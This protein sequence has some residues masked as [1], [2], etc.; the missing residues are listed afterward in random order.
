MI[1]AVL[2]NGLIFP[3]D[4][5][6]SHWKDGQ[7]LRVK[8]LRARTEESPEEIDRQFQALEAAAQ[9]IDPKDCEI[10]EAALRE[11]DRRAKE[12]MR[13]EMGLP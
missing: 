12:W 11:A 10:V 8:A 3:L 13:R 7:K 5:L 4:P 1:R 6:P 2:R 9:A